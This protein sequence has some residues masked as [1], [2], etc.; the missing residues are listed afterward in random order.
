MDLRIGSLST[1]IGGGVRPGSSLS[2]ASGRAGPSAIGQLP[3]LLRRL[4]LG[5]GSIPRACVGV[6]SRAQERGEK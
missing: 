1:G 6:S 2:P 3:D 5:H 4:P